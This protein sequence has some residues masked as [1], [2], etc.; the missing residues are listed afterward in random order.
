MP[1]EAEDTG[2]SS[3]LSI[4]FVERPSPTKSLIINRPFRPYCYFMEINERQDESRRVGRD[5]L[6]ESLAWPDAFI[7]QPM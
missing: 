6:A 7:P 4:L 5:I 3:L 1:C 2:A